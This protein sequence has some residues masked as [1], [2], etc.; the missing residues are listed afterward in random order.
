MGKSAVVSSQC[1]LIIFKRVPHIK[2]G[3]KI[4]AQVSLPSME[5]NFLLQGNFEL[6]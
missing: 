2:M 3:V 1:N 6:L 5:E 4:N